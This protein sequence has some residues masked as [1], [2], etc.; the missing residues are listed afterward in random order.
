M[1]G[2]SIT[3]SARFD[4][5]HTGNFYMHISFRSGKGASLD[6]LGDVFSPIVES[7][8]WKPTCSTR[9]GNER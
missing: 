6:R 1:N 9:P 7:S 4:D 3:A 8:D 2:C 5:S